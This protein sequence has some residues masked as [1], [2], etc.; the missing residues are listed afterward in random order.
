MR[1]CV[2]VLLIFTVLAPSLHAQEAKTYPFTKHQLGINSTTLLQQILSFGKELDESPAPFVQYKM[3]LGSIGLRAGFAGDYN[4]ANEDDGFSDEKSWFYEARLGAEMRTN[5]SQRWKLFYGFEGLFRNQETTVK[6]SD[7]FA[8]VTN[9]DTRLD[10]GGGPIAGLQF[11]ISKHFSI[12]TEAGL[13]FRDLS[14]V[15]RV[16]NDIFQGNNLKSETNSEQIE[17][18]MP[19]SLFFVVKF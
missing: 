4:T 12:Y 9:K 5:L 10:F 6:T 18:E 19:A 17:F 3:Y 7:G 16:N 15:S 13:Y 2:V 1:Y 8:T 11:E 14:F